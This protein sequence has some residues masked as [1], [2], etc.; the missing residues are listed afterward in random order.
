M[1]S[2]KNCTP[3]CIECNVSLLSSIVTKCLSYINKMNQLKYSKWNCDT[4][5]DITFL[6]LII[7]EYSSD[8]H[9]RW[10]IN[11]TVYC[12]DFYDSV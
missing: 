3:N 4:V 7:G 8:Q 5:C 9:L 11:Y 2:F 1:I 6:D 10:F 12:H